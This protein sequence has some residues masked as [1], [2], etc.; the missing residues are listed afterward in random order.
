MK[1]PICIDDLLEEF[2]ESVYMIF[3]H[4]MSGNGLKRTY[5]YDMY[6]IKNVDSEVLVN[7][8]IDFRY[9]SHTK[10]LQIYI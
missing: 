2:D 10:T 9:N 3:I 8:V 6:E 4:C 7:Y 1:E 5:M